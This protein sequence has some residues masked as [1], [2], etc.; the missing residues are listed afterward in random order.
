MQSRT[1]KPI[2]K[3]LSRKGGIDSKQLMKMK[4]RN[5]VSDEQTDE[6][7][8]KIF[9]MRDM[10]S[11]HLERVRKDRQQKNQKRWKTA[12]NGGEGKLSKV[13]YSP[14]IFTALKSYHTYLIWRA[15][16]HIYSY[17][18]MHIFAAPATVMALGGLIISANC[19]TELSCGILRRCYFV[20]FQ[21]FIG[22]LEGS[23]I[24]G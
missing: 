16:I 4:G 11:A 10:S 22:D 7:L 12:I 14:E 13:L 2:R 1:W 24:I 18:C 17:V 15:H 23:Q 8:A 9:K 19:K 5:K 3:K 6:Y 20:I 21:T